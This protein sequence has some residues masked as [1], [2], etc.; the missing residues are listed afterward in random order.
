MPKLS[1]GSW[2]PGGS[3][4]PRA[5]STFFFQE[6]ITLSTGKAFQFPPLIGER[7]SQKRPYLGKRQ[8]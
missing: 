7:T 8:G 4:A 2:P 5:K 1:L 3:S 6:I